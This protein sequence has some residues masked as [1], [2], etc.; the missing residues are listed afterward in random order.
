MEAFERS[1]YASKCFMYIII[2]GTPW[3]SSVAPFTISA[4]YVPTSIGSSPGVSVF[5]PNRAVQSLHTDS[6]GVRTCGS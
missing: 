3:S 2:L 4:A 5:R 6:V 1:V